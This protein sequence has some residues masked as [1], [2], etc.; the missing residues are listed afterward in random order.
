[1]GPP[2]AVYPW[3]DAGDEFSWLINKDLF[4]P[5]AMDLWWDGYDNA[6]YKIDEDD[7]GELPWSDANG[8][9]TN[10]Y[11][12][13]ELYEFDRFY[14]LQ[15]SSINSNYNVA[16]DIENLF[17]ASYVKFYMFPNPWLTKL[18]LNHDSEQWKSKYIYYG[19]Y[20][21]SQNFSHWANRLEDTG[22]IG[23]GDNLW[24]SGVWEAGYL[25]DAPVPVTSSFFDTQEDVRNHPEWPSNDQI[26][27][28]WDFVTDPE[29]KYSL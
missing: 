8:D 10:S 26:G 5:G 11:R 2:A 13:S 18:N 12:N 9:P 4:S 17:G 22:F 7:L 16:K 28:F 29:R 24:V 21:D 20:N 3:V 25:N 23:G 15:I 19:G 1:M 27:M 14:R 6:Y